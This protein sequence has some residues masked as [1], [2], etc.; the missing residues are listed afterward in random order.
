MCIRDSLG[1]EDGVA[2]DVAPDPLGAPPGV[3]RQ[4]L[5]QPVADAQHLLG[6]ECQVGG[7][8]LDGLGKGGL[9]D[10]RPRVRQHHPLARGA[11]GQQH[12]GGRVGAAQAD[13]LDVAVDVAHRVEDGAR[14]GEGAAGGIDVERDVLPGRRVL[15]IHQLGDHVARRRFV[16]RRAQEDHASGEQL[17]VGVQGPEPVGGA[18]GD[19]R[20]CVTVRGS[21][22]GRSSASPALDHL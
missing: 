16:D 4:R 21:M 8:P 6:P 20:E 13:G 7:L 11:G 17:G 19:L 5:H 15:Q 10:Q 22:H 14:R 1:V 2:L 9:P 12:G 18:L 3:Q